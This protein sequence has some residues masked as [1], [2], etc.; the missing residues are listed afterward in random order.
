MSGRNNQSQLIPHLQ[1]TANT[2]LPDVVC[3]FRLL[4]VAS[5]C[6]RILRYRIKFTWDGPPRCQHPNQTI[7]G[8]LPV[9]F[10]FTS[11]WCWVNRR[12][13]EVNQR[14]KRTANPPVSFDG[15]TGAGGLLRRPFE[16]F[17]NK[18]PEVIIRKKRKLIRRWFFNLNRKASRCG[19]SKDQAA[20]PLTCCCSSAQLN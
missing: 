20:L 19:G 13:L 1:L 17:L 2:P 6:F 15:I 18:K 12:W 14:N 3:Y 16:T 10:R 7:S 8:A 11:G 9:C 5:G 4:P